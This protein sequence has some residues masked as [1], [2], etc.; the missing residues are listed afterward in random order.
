MTLLYIATE[1][2]LSEAVADHL[3]AKVNHGLQVIVRMRQNGCGYL[4][5]KFPELVRTA[6]KIPVFLLTDLDRIECPP[7][8]I[9]SWSGK[10]D[11]PP[12]MLF[13]VAVREIE[14]WLLADRE[15]FAAFFGVPLTK[16]PLHPETIADPK[17][18]LLNLV[19]RH[20]KREIKTAILPERGSRAKIGFGYN[21]MLSRFVEEHWSIERAMVAS[22]SLARTHRRLTELNTRTLQKK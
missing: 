21:Q 1:D 7:V 8:L 12:G 22:D 17:Q 4:K 15:G 2:A 20:S 6:R 3:V 18:L 16:L 10:A 5:I 19:R 9:D 11:I 13:R 14:A